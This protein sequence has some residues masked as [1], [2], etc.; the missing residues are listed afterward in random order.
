MPSYLHPGVYIEEIPSGSKPIEGVSTSTT[1]FIGATFRG[2]VNSP[3]LIGSWDE[4]VAQFGDF[5]Q[6]TG[7]QNESDATALAVRAFY[8]NG[9]RAA[10][11]CRL[12]GGE[13]ET[14]AVTIS[15]G[16]GAV[17]EVSASS[18]GTW[19]NNLAVAV[20]ANGADFNFFV[21]TVNDGDEFLP[22]ASE[23]FK[24]V[25]LDE[26]EDNFIEKVVNGSSRLVLVT[27]AEDASGLP[28]FH[29]PAGAD[30][31]DRFSAL[32]EAAADTAAEAD[33]YNSF[34]T[35]ILRKVSD[36][37]II[38]L[39]GQFMPAD[40]SGN[41]IIA[42]TI[43]HCEATMSRVVI[44]DT[45]NVE[46]DDASAVNDMVLPTSTYSVLY[47]PWVT[48]NNPLFNA[49][50]NPTA[51][52]TIN[53]APSA[54]AAGVWTKIDSNRGVWKAPA[55][56]ET[57]INVAGTAFDVEDLEQDFLNPL[58]VNCVRKRPGYGPVLWG[59]RTLA[60]KANPEWRYVPVR[61][62]A[63]FVEQS[64]YNG[65]QWAVFEPNDH[66]LWSSLRANISSFMNGLFRAGAFQG[67]TADD[68]YFVRCGLGD[69]MTQGDIDRGQVIIVVGFA[70]L[71][72]AEFVILRL[73]QKIGQ[74]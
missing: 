22:I 64:I 60:T 38:V 30:P 24:G 2:P 15:N 68:A 33:D 12:L 11:V 31:A 28:D 25:S 53:I 52:T 66:P 13:P 49:D 27:V 9:G 32:T 26:T 48:I 54:I 56:V 10:Y 71:K 51:A 18:P 73:Q 14:A 21:G 58:G 63:I 5:N 44:V 70:P 62:T 17:L 3:T 47:Y 29:D 41:E 4:Y 72:P 61:R 8:Q 59:S 35:N 55:G 6:R 7:I 46:L 69:T 57:R 50:T 67:K 42:N 19:A 37:S 20:Y 40:G 39:P 65:I 23:S 74:Q 16:D 34:Y 1:A 45:E 36:V 43:N